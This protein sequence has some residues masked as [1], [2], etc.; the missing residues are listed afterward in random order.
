MPLMQLIVLAVVAMTGLVA[1]RLARVHLGRSPLPE[2]RG[3]RLFLLAFVLVPPI[4]FGALASSGSPA[5]LPIYVVI[6]ASLVSVMWLVAQIAAWVLPGPRGQ[7][8]R[9]ALTGREVQPED[10]PFDPPITARL[11]AIVAGVDRANVAFPRGTAFPGQI[12]TSGFRDSW[13]TLDAATVTLESGLAENHRL[14][15]GAASGAR[16]TAADAR[17]RL[18]T[19]RGLAIADGQSWAAI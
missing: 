19:L 7:R 9:L 16:R 18:N 8:V 4:A 2:G 13:E 10:E 6:L 12:H 3:R 5:S 14:G 15:L 11:A 17:G 1:L